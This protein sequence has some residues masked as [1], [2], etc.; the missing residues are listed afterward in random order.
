VYKELWA[1][2]SLMPSKLALKVG[3][4]ALTVVQIG[5]SLSSLVLA[6]LV[7]VARCSRTEEPS[8]E[9]HQEVISPWEQM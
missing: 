1:V 7:Y 9:L 8:A 6:D 5:A 4:G 2:E 3:L